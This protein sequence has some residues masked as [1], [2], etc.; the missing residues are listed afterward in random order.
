MAEE[1]AIDRTGNWL[2]SIVRNWKIRRRIF[3]MGPVRFGGDAKEC[4]EREGLFFGNHLVDWEKVCKEQ[5]E[6]DKRL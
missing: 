4:R 6:L 1:N 3:K 5:A 2:F